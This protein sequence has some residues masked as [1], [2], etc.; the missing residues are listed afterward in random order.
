MS[1][2]GA[3]DFVAPLHH[4]RVAFRER[5]VTSE[6]AASRLKVLQ[7]LEKLHS[8]LGSLSDS[9]TDKQTQHKRSG[10]WSVSE[11]DSQKFDSM[12]R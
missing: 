10:S 9:I 5:T 6:V 12:Q 3:R 4:V 8:C 7:D 2:S 1:E 11:I